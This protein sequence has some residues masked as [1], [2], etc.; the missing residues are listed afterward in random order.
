MDK[1][2][3]NYSLNGCQQKE[4]KHKDISVK[5]YAP[6]ADLSDIVKYYWIVEVKETTGDKK[7]AKI[8]PTGFPELIFHFGDSPSIITIAG[9][10]YDQ[11]SESIIAGQTTQPVMIDMNPHLNCFCIKLHA[12]GLSAL[13]GIK[14]TEFVN[15]AVCLD[16]VTPRENRI[17]YEQLSCAADDQ[18]RIGIIEYHLRYMLKKYRKSVNPITAKAISAIRQ[19][20]KHQI[21]HLANDFHISSRTLQRRFKDDVGISAKMFC[22]ITR[23]NKVYHLIK[24]HQHRNLQ[25]IC[26]HLGYYD[27]PHLINE[28]RE[29]SGN[30]PLQF[31]K[32]ENV[33]NKV[34]TNQIK[35]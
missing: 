31:F 30:S 13:F 25:N 26:F 19:C 4:K 29:F 35:F 21:M 34:F 24:H 32:N 20:D 5:Y 1:T 12:W 7:T 2:K 18:E 14:S 17:I 15:Q 10:D 22:R 11:V 6:A 27:L 23:F 3:E 16:D 33:Y 9:S 28:F 8:S